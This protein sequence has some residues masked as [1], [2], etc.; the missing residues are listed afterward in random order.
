MAGLKDKLRRLTGSSRSEETD[1]IDSIGKEVS[2]EAAPSYESSTNGACQNARSGGNLTEDLVPEET[3]AA[4]FQIEE[5]EEEWRNLGAAL[6]RNSHGSFIRRRQV[7]SSGHRHGMYCLG[8]L[9]EWAGFLEAY[10]PGGGRIPIGADQLLFFDT[11]TTGLGHG[12]GNVAFM[13]GIGF[14]EAESFI[15][16]QLFIRNPMEELA[17]LAYVK[18]LLEQYPY[19]VTYN[20][21][22]F[23]WPLLANRFV[24]HRMKDDL[25]EPVHLDFL[26]S[27]RSLW[28]TTLPSCRL[29]QVEES[30]LGF[31]R[32]DDMPGSMAPELYFLYLAEKRVRDIAPV[33][34][35]NELDIV[36]LAGLALLFGQALGGEW[37]LADKQ[38]EERFRLGLWLHR[39]DKTDLS[40]FIMDGLLQD[41]LLA[42]EA[43]TDRY[44]PL[45]MPL[46]IFYKQL[47]R[48][49]DAEKLWLLSIAADR[50][51]GRAA[52]PALG[53]YVEL[54]MHYEHR[55]KDYE[56]ALLYT[57][58]ALQWAEKRQ[59]VLQAAVRRSGQRGRQRS[60]GRRISGEPEELLALARSSALGAGGNQEEAAPK[61]A[62]SISGLEKRANRLRRKLIKDEARN[63]VGKPLGEAYGKRRAAT[64][65]K[66]AES[67]P[68]EALSLRPSLRKSKKGQAGGSS[69]SQGA[70][71]EPMT[72]F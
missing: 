68:A 37:D 2:P 64:T 15:V 14:W 70:G 34:L 48:W 22:S 31:V 3:R 52:G 49:E 41:I 62:D 57:E 47:G 16:E 21:K 6:V 63:T 38:P 24:M 1:Q 18:P 45:L 20:G 7:Y 56:K 28:R 43:E 13:I 53:P 51:A 5:L 4:L 40:G 65:T 60:S 17:M 44:S 19:L 36:S 55:L 9:R 50:Q 59:S 54:A 35:H 27:S 30:R 46:G 39:M 29:G 25:P 26:Y 61:G 71:S 69:A 11:E 32:Q 8:D 58:E 23:D 67:G 33:F 42:G 72:L 10:T 66:E 12:A